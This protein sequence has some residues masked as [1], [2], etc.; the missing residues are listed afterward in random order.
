MFKN[1]YRLSFLILILSVIQVV[2]I[3]AESG[4]GSS[5]SAAVDRGNADIVYV[6]AVEERSGSWTFIVTVSHPD[7]GWDDYADGWDIV[8]PDETVIKADESSPFTRLLLHPHVGEQP[9]T[10]SQGGLSIPADISLVKVR[11]HD[12]ADGFGGREVTVD[13]NKSMGDD[14][15]VIRKK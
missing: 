8:L 5:T 4:S 2:S 3:A 9:F 6:K 14:F 10:R 15:E 11:A 7:K 1:N 12:L 13:L